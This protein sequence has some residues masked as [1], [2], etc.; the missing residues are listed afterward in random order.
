MAIPIARDLLDVVKIWINI[1]GNNGSKR[2]DIDIYCQGPE[3]RSKGFSCRSLFIKKLLTKEI[4]PTTA[5]I[6]KI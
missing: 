5:L 3:W 2:Y 4:D 6:H 1:D